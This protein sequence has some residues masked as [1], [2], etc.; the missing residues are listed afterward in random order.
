MAICR[1]VRTPVAKNRQRRSGRPAA[2]P[3]PLRIGIAGTK[4][5]L[6]RCAGPAN[7]AWSATGHLRENESGDA[8]CG[9]NH[10]RKGKYS[11]ATERTHSQGKHHR[12]GRRREDTRHQPFSGKRPNGAMTEENQRQGAPCNGEDAGCRAVAER[13]YERRNNMSADR[14]PD[15]ETGRHPGGGDQI[16]A[17][18]NTRTAMDEWFANADVPLTPGMNLGSVEAIKE[19]VGA[20][21]GCAALPGTAVRNRDVGTSIV[22][23][24]LSPDLLRTLALVMR[25][26][27]TRSKSLRETIRVLRRIRGNPG[28]GQD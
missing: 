4:A 12:R 18:G 17:G 6:T 1:P 3:G 26:D 5:G 24:S 11:S 20:G 19:P 22:A 14:F 28:A 13:E 7:R 23:R 15:G 16:E 25:H 2:G 9:V 10:H 8:D 27:K 21:L